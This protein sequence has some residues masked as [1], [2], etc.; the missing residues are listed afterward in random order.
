MLHA[1]HTVASSA[2]A[3]AGPD[4][5]GGSGPNNRTLAMAGRLNVLWR[6]LGVTQHHDAVTGTATPVIRHFNTT[7]L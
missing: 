5:P 7:A 1:L 2:A 3:L 6:A 4:T